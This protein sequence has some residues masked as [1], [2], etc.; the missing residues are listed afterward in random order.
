[1]QEASW[2]ENIMTDK[3]ILQKAIEKAEKNGYSW[4]KEIYEIE[5]FKEKFYIGYSPSAIIIIDKK[6]NLIDTRI[7]M[8]K[9]IF[10]HSFA[11]AFWGESLLYDR[12]QDETALLWQECDDIVSCCLHG[13][14]NKEWEYRLQQMVI[15]KEPLKYLVRFL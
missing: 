2:E 4:L 5:G 9:V 8:E 15:A 6:E 12:N 14:K 11:K 10:S 1:M 3:E 7:N 13:G